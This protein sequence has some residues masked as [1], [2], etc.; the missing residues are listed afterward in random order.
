MILYSRESALQEGTKPVPNW[1]RQRLKGFFPERLFERVRW[2]HASN[3]LTL[4]SLA[5]VTRPKFE[6]ITLRDVV[7]FSD[8]SNSQRLEIWIHELLH[9][10]QVEQAGLHEFARGY[11]AN[12]PHIE[13]QTKASARKMVR[14]ARI[15]EQTRQT[16]LPRSAKGSRGSSQVSSPMATGLQQKV[17]R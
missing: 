4:D 6:A 2:T 5:A 17:A 1:V 14:L 7:V 15:Q 13:A 12:W 9:V 3:R 16:D 11:I 10:Q 8:Y